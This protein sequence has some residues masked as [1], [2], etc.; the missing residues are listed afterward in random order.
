MLVC[1]WLHEC[2]CVHQDVCGPK[3]GLGRCVCFLSALS[4]SQS[5]LSTACSRHFST[6]ITSNIVDFDAFFLK[7]L[8]WLI[9]H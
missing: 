6:C 9:S 8:M 5:L 2:A 1:L 3:L 4:V 7:L